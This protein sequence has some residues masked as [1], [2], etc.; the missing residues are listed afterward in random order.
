VCN[1]D[2]TRNKSCGSDGSGI[3][4][5]GGDELT[6]PFRHAL[7]FSLYAVVARTKSYTYAA[8]VW[9]LSI[10]Q[11]PF[12]VAP[13]RMLIVPI[14]NSH[15]HR[16]LSR[17]GVA[18]NLHVSN[19]PSPLVPRYDLKGSQR[20]R[21]TAPAV[22][23]G[24][25]PT[26][27]TVRPYLMARQ[28]LSNV[29]MRVEARGID[30]KPPNDHSTPLPSLLPRFHPPRSVK[31][32]SRW[33]LAQ[34]LLDENLLETMPAAPILVDEPDKYRLQ[35]GET[36]TRGRF[37]R[38]YSQLSGWRTGSLPCTAPRQ[39]AAPRAHRLGLCA[40]LSPC[41]VRLSSRLANSQP[42]LASPFSSLR[43]SH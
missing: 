7:R 33:A 26:E 5:R 39:G 24:F 40:T 37:S 16:C 28:R 2:A 43:P 32:P 20:S 12:S 29:P 18:P 11:G 9:E 17:A 35:V 3:S 6:R 15:T 4:F 23:K 10:V 27:D 13:C 31:L 1:S 19:L 34:V 30:G 41:V 8:N 21:Y 36:P 14:R 38:W 42:R 22:A 25:S